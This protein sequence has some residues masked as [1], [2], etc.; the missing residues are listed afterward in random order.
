VSSR[1]YIA[2]KLSARSAATGESFPAI[3]QH[4]PG[5]RETLTGVGD[6]RKD[7]GD[8]NHQQRSSID[9]E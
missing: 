6:N 8:R 2:S 1:R 4:T 5:T 7:G 9:Q 3:T